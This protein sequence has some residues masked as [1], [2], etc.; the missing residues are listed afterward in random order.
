MQVLVSVLK[1]GQVGKTIKK[2][3]LMYSNF[4]KFAVPENTPPPF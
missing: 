2:K 4:G 3:K 1:S